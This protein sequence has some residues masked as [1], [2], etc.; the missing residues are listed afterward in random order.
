MTYHE[1]ISVILHMACEFMLAIK[2]TVYSFKIFRA[3]FIAPY[4]PVMI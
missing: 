3:K 4:N 1:V 2:L